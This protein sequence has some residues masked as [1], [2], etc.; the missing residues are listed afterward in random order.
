MSF[1]KAL[2]SNLNNMNSINKSINKQNS[3]NNFSK[4]SSKN[5][6]LENLLKS[7]ILDNQ[8]KKIQPNIMYSSKLIQDVIESSLGQLENV[9]GFLNDSIEKINKET[10]GS[11]LPKFEKTDLESLIISLKAI[12]ELSDNQEEIQDISQGFAIFLINFDKSSKM[13]LLLKLAGIDISYLGIIKQYP[14]AKD[15][16]TKTINGI[17]KNKDVFAFINQLKPKIDL[18]LANKNFINMMKVVLKMPPVQT[19]IQ[20][21]F[22]DKQLTEIIIRFYLTT[23]E[24]AKSDFSELNEDCDKVWQATRSFI[25]LFC[26]LVESFRESIPSR[27]IPEQCLNYTN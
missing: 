18:L 5:D 8:N 27:K 7:S 13:K 15:I 22:P 11:P 9:F 14:F 25:G 17:I 16:Y 1:L 2:T 21:Y 3:F 6:E 20:T 19:Q 23:R 24:I 26:S 12:E 10:G 4:K